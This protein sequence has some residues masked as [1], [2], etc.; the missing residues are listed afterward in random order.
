MQF[1][2]C[3]QKLDELELFVLYQI[4]QYLTISDLS[5]INLTNRYL[6][7]CIINFIESETRKCL[8]TLKNKDM[9][10]LIRKAT[11]ESGRL[12]GKLRRELL[13]FCEINGEM[14]LPQELVAITSLTQPHVTD[15]SSSFK[16]FDSLHSK[17]KELKLLTNLCQF[18]VI[19]RVPL[20]N[21]H[22]G[23]NWQDFRLRYDHK[24]LRNVV[25]CTVRTSIASFS[26]KFMCVP[27]GSYQILIHIKVRNLQA[28]KTFTVWRFRMCTRLNGKNL[29]LV[30]ENYGGCKG[31]CGDWYFVMSEVFRLEEE[32]GVEV[33]WW[34]ECG[35]A[36]AW[37]HI[38]LRYFKRPRNIQC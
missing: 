34:S 18:I 30:R 9:T 27:P 35:F 22:F 33:W 17:I 1:V 28:L 11:S 10:R 24:L 7:S 8:H 6:H 12:R 29:T 36:F 21:N 38:E 19:V 26:H 31:S 13:F 3:V 15:Y 14:L 37:D 25:Q 4:F 32:C 2:A 20:R 16:Y 5:N 23:L